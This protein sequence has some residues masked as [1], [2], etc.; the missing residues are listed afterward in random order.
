MSFI[1]SEDPTVAALIEKERHRQESTLLF[2]ID[3]RSA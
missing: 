1:T 2:A 3:S